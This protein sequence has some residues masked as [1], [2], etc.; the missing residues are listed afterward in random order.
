MIKSFALA[1]GSSGN[2]FYLES[3]K[4]KIL[5]DVGLSFTKSKEIL[6]S[7]GIDINEI[8]DVFL[9][10]EHSDH[11]V[12]LKSFLKNLNCNYYS[13]KGTLEILKLSKEDLIRFENVKHHSILSL[14]DLRVFVLEKPHDGL[15]SVSYVCQIGDKKIGFFTDLGHVNFE[16]L[17]YLKQL[18]LVYFEVN[19]SEEY[20]KENCQNM[21]ENYLNRLMSDI[22]HLGLKQSKEAVKDFAQDNQIIVLSHISENTITY[23]L[24]YEGIKEIIDKRGVLCELEVSYQ[25]EPTKT[26]YLKPYNREE[27]E[28]EGVEV[29]EEFKK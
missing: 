15:E 1:S 19:Y 18:D 7:R 5:I 22:G 9:T 10:H 29:L 20:V 21:N 14:E 26:F 8:T 25:G 3:Q 27:I 23:K 24:A 16:I 13:T 4:R 6:E 12:G 17:N 2:S 11:V 28:I